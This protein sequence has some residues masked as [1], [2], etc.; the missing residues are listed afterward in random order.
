[1]ISASTLKTPRHQNNNV[2]RP[3]PVSNKQTDSV[4]AV[5][6]AKLK[7]AEPNNRYE[8]EADRMAEQVV[9]M[10]SP[11]FHA[12]ADSTPAINTESQNKVIQRM[13]TSCRED[14][15]LIQTKTT[16]NGMPKITP[17]ID[18]RIR[19]LNGGG[20]PM[21]LKDRGY[22]EPRFGTDF[23]TVR[24]HN[25]SRSANIAKSI[26][27]RAFTLGRNVVF[28]AG[29][30]SHNSLASRKL[31]AHELTHILQQPDTSSRIIRRQPLT[32]AQRNQIC[33]NSTT[34]Q[35]NPSARQPEL[36]PTYEQW[37]TSFAGMVSFSSNDTAPGHAA[38]NQFTVLGTRGRRLGDSTATTQNEATP[39]TGTA[40]R[41]E[42]FIDHPTNQWVV[43]CLPPNLRAAAYQLPS[44]CADIA[45]ILRHV[46]LAAHR[47]TETYRG[48][49]VGDAAGNANQRRVRGLI[50][51]VYSGNVAGMVNAYS[52]TQGSRLTNFNHLSNLLHPGDILVW[53][54]RK[55]TS[56]RG[57]T[58]SQ[59]TGGHTQTI[60]EIRRS[61][62]TISAINVLQ[63]NQ[64]IFS[65][66]A[67]AI[68]QHRGA[69]NTD[70]DSSAG[71]AL[72]NLPSRRVER[73]TAISRSNIQHPVTN[74]DIWG[75][76]DSRRANGSV[77]KFT[78]LVSAGPPRASTRPRMRRIAGQ[79][80]RRLSDWFN[81]LRNAS[82]SRLHG[83]LEATLLEA[84]SIIDGGNTVTSTDATELGTRAGENL[85]SRATAAV[86]RLLGVRSRSN[87][88]LSGDVGT[89]THFEPL[90]SMRAMIRALGAIHPTSYHGNPGAVTNVRT[91]FTIIDREFNVA[92]RGGSSI[93]FNRSI[94]SG[95]ELV[96]VLV[97]GFD[98][99]SANP[100]PA[101][102]WNPAGATAMALDNKQV[103]LG[104]NNKAAIESVVYP[105]SF[106]Q[107]NQGI[108]ERVVRSSNADAV[109]TVSLAP[110][111][112]ST[113]P[114]QIEQFTVGMHA[115][116]RLQP[117]RLF[118][119]EPANPQ[120]PATASELRGITGSGN[121][122][123]ETG[124]A[125]DLAGIAADTEQKNRRG[126]VTT[127]RPS[128]A[129]NITFRLPTQQLAQQ[130]VTALGLTQTVT[131][132][133][134]SISNPQAIRS[135]INNSVRITDSRGNTADIRITLNNTPF[136]ATI[137]EG[138]GGSFLSNEV[139]FRTQQQLR[140]QGSSATSFHT[141][142]PPAEAAAALIPQSG[143]RSARRN[144]L[145]SARNT[146]S[147]LVTTMKR[148]I[149]AVSVRIVKN[150]QQGS[151]GP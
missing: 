97:T 25:D 115:L 95:A 150:R 47:R 4:K 60:S 117:H 93:S 127:Q 96:K 17:S 124:A 99:F 91:T 114:V 27:A 54:H 151:G 119:S 49:T 63:G 41:G 9:M 116:T 57:R 50:R 77:E 23:S 120:N 102:D 75:D 79:T 145:W 22:F 83:V 34:Q 56:R 67:T 52:N 19:S 87:R 113:A 70:P 7:I 15:E 66:A 106:A 8:Q 44:D 125:A 58:R 109:L 89:R 121:A 1:M 80:V 133:Q 2:T 69:S 130:L 18:S 128:V 21:T 126:Q 147:R 35:P 149:R 103:N 72:R 32:Q 78:I 82:A 48:W 65:D 31:F 138:P 46:W 134:I 6:Q 100:P 94:R 107:F 24:V 3:K 14:K 11:R 59:R 45:V 144:A 68:L 64:P 148:L 104:G 81:S 98:P 20:Q 123:I 140:T 51:D 76:I 92:A 108:V 110:G 30:Y 43:N 16:G 101:G 136:R 36:H 5:L 29:E 62:N 86:R 141:H 139:A 42:E 129:S 39:V 131:S 55:T 73:S 112:A 111:L 37:L 74:A 146:V 85:W 10:P 61:G 33:Y 28:G 143:S 26:N 142:V 53:E 118:P 88:L 105:V 38:A 122:I 90:H 137:I 84:R 135:I 40:R 13:C 12:A 132:R 71:M